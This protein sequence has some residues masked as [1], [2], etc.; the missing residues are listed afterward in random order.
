MVN[1]AFN[2]AGGAETRPHK[3]RGR[4]RDADGLE[5]SLARERDADG[6]RPAAQAGRRAGCDGRP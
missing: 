4:P 3:C 2:G 1:V 5:F 6:I